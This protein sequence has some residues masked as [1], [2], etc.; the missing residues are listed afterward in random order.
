MAIRA[1]TP[2]VCGMIG[3]R[4][5]MQLTTVEIEGR[6]RRVLCAECLEAER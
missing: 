2:D 6:G 3:C 4:N 1:P 5:T